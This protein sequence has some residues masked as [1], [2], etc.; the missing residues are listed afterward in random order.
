MDNLVVSRQSFI[1]PAL[2][3]GLLFLLP[4]CLFS[5]SLPAFARAADAMML[6]S[7]LA[8]ATVGISVID[9][10][11]GQTVY[12]HNGKKAMITGST[13]KAVTTATALRVL[14]PDFRFQTKLAAS[15]PVRNG[16]IAGDL[17][18]VG[19]GDPTLGSDRIR[20][21]DGMQTLFYSW[22]QALKAQGITE[23]TGSVIGDDSRYSTQMT[24][25][26]WGWEDMGNYY[27]A[28]ASGL[29]IA[30][31]TYRL[32]MSS[33]SR[34]GS[35]TTILRTD[36]E[37]PIFFINEVTAGPA[38]SGDNVYI[39]GSPYTQIRYVRGTMPPGKSLF[40]I[41][42]SIPDPALI[43][44]RMLQESLE[45]CGINVGS[46]SSTTRL[47][48]L[49]GKGQSQ[50]SQTLLTHSSASLSEIAQTTNYRSI[51][52]YAEALAKEIAV[53][54]GEE[55]T[56]AKGATVAKGYWVSQ[57]VSSAGMHPRDGSGLSPNNLFTP[58][59]FTAILRKMNTGPGSAAFRESLP[60][61]GQSGALSSKMRGTAAEGRVRAKSG[62]ISGVRGYVG[63]VDLPDGRRLAFAFIANHFEGSV[64]SV[65]RKWEA[66]MVKLAEGR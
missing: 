8:P 4:V 53:A 28:G 64:G 18:I 23:I 52:L 38:G 17:I 3:A 12:A 56:S 33:P 2:I 10:S 40:S 11:N 45:S 49:S 55:G 63:Y 59:Q 57:G 26:N 43:C 25:G 60:V 29:N 42:G 58:D 6:E 65:S 16:V 9:V 5:Q 48:A 44:A 19:S 34:T 27:G 62:Y 47:R 54:R 7:S 14:G 13:L 41:K 61:A 35:A 46:S 32:D 31:N 15:V 39:Y 21:Q 50:P 66:L 36:P 1:P 22:A 51:N 30:E 37:M 24:P 20:Q